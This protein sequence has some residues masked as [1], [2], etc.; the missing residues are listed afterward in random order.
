MSVLYKIGRISLTVLC[1]LLLVG[2]GSNE[3][4]ER[5][6]GIS[7][8]KGDILIEGVRT[9]GFSQADPTIREGMRILI[10]DGRIVF[11]GQTEQ[12]LQAETIIDGRGLTLIPG[13]TDMHVHIWDEAELGAY[14]AHG[15]TTVRNMSGMPFHLRLAERINSGELDGPRL[16]T[17]GPILNSTGPNMQINH[18]IVDDPASA[19]AAVQWQYEAGFRRLKVYS[20][21]TQEAYGA[22]TEEAGKLGM[23]ITGHT[24]EGQRGPGIPLTRSFEISFEEVLSDEF[25]TIEHVE[26]IVWHGLRA[27]Q[28]EDRARVLARKIAASR[29]A[30]TPTLLAHHNLY[31]V[32]QEGEA[33]LTR[34]GTEWLNPFIQETEAGSHQRWLQTPPGPVGRDDAFYGQV[35]RIF[36]EEGVLLVAGSD[37]GI[38]TN[39]PGLSLIEELE[40][41]IKAGLTPYRALQTATYNPSVVL[42]EPDRG[43]LSEGCVADLLLYDCDPLNE[44]ACLRQPHAVISK[45]KSFDRDD[46]ERLLAAAGKSN[47]ERTQTNVMSGLQVQGTPIDSLEE[48]QE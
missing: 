11:A 26:S 37:A 28:D 21:L 4:P 14:L 6:S 13:L 44:I 33:A 23:I 1:G 41:L 17:T 7:A 19:R 10:D 18:Q 25:E 38:F 3:R 20:N 5:Y 35:T 34:P 12:F 31:R 30:V 48:R 40:L 39:I 43:C 27:N 2:C 9:I 36:D 47:I 16:L 29:V 45:G 22:I 24:P 42:N 8:P 15:V 32:A 46:L